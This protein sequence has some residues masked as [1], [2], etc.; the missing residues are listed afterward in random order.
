ML[1]RL[2]DS[3]NHEF[4]SETSVCVHDDGVQLLMLILYFIITSW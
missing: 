4:Q 1:R 2:A 3:E